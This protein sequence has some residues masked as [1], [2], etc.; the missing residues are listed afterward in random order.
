MSL[1]DVLL[2][3]ALGALA[4][5]FSLNEAYEAGAASKGTQITKITNDLGVARDNAK[6]LKDALTESNLKI[7]A[8]EA[9]SKADEAEKARLQKLSEDNAGKGQARVDAAKA[10]TTSTDEVLRKYWEAE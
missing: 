1:Q 8:F 9:A 2:W 3:G 7:Q 6:Q 10:I 4:F 5:G